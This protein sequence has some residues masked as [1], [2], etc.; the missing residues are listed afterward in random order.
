MAIPVAEAEQALTSSRVERTVQLLG[1]RGYALAPGR[2]ASLC[3]GGPVSSEQVLAAAASRPGLL[4]RDGLVVSTNGAP[5]TGSILGRAQAHDRE[6][7]PYV[8]STLRFVRAFVALNPYILSVAIAGSLASG[9][10]RETDDVDLN[11]MVD[12]GR[13][14]VAYVALNILSALHALAH[15]GKPVDAL[16]RRPVA[17]RL[18]TANL[19]LERSQCFPLARQDESMAFELLVSEPVYGSGFWCDML[20]AN[21]GLLRHFPQLAT[22]P[23]PLAARGRSRLPAW[24][25]PAWFDRPARIFGRAGWRYMQWTRRQQP[26]ALARV[27]YVRETMRPYALFD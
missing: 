7:G 19:I 1:R 23:H 25:F 6:A 5:D 13:R 20:A 10:F 9:G 21:P 8:A 3:L 26:E 18:V 12:D 15:R 16:S 24:V 17:P 22:R 2:L 14:H 27:A 4:L 11:L